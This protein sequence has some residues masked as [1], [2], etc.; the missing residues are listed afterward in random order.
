MNLK[1][2]REI[3]AANRATLDE[4]GVARLRVFGSTARGEATDASDIDL[5]IDFN[6]RVGLC[7]LATVKEKLEQLLGTEVDLVTEG[8][9]HPALAPRI[10]AEA[11]DAA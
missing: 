4:L 5:L 11:I 1:D 7:H 9:L 3:L 8:A 6:R 10:L 2:A